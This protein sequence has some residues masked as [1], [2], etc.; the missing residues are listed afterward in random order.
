MY[1]IVLEGK[2][3]RDLRRLS[4]E[5]HERVIA[6]IHGL[7]RTVFSSSL[8]GEIKKRQSWPEE[9]GGPQP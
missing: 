3:E 4:A 2:A 5:M 7:A 6:A 9:R 8:R 1:R